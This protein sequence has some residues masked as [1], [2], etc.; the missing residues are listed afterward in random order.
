M[1]DTWIRPHG[2]GTPESYAFPDPTA[3][4]RSGAIWRARHGV[5][6]LNWGDGISLAEMCEAYR[7]LLTHPWGTEGSIKKIRE[8]RRCLRIK[9][10]L[11]DELRGLSEV[12]P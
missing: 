10:Y 1:S 12:K 6:T 9:T 5:I 7:D 4:A 8:L 3:P 2:L 11:R